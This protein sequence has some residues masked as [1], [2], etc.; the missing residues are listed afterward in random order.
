MTVFKRSG[1]YGSF[2]LEQGSKVEVIWSEG[3]SWGESSV[4]GC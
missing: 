4:E 1:G 3:Q 2:K